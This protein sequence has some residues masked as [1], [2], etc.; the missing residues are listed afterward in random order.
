[1]AVAAPAFPRGSGKALRISLDGRKIPG[2]LS[3]LFSDNVYLP[4]YCPTG[5]EASS[6]DFELALMHVHS[7][8]TWLPRRRRRRR[9]TRYL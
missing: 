1:M 6:V 5:S 4:L 3:F 9:Q 2:G 7:F 8:Q